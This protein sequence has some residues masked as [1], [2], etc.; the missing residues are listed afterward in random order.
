[1]AQTSLRWPADTDREVRDRA[2]RAMR[3][4]S[5]EILHLV[6]LGLAAEAAG[7][8]VASLTGQKR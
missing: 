3:T 5:M 2:A 7:Y 8:T 6:L 1:M 4:N